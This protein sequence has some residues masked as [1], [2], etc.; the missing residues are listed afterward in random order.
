MPE[1]SRDDLLD[2]VDR[3]GKCFGHLIVIPNLIGMTSLGISAR[4]VGV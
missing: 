2:L 4:E 3:Y 1:L